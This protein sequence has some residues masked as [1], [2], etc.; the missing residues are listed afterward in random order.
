MNSSMPS[1]TPPVGVISTHVRV[2]RIQV[3]GDDDNTP[4]FSTFNTK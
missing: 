3:V 1:T 4:F 2:W